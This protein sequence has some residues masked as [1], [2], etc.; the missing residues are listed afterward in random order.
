MRVKVDKEQAKDE[1]NERQIV[2]YAGC[3]YRAEL[4]EFLA[5]DREDTTCPKCHADEVI[6][7]I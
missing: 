2:S 7:E 5:K 1:R 6:Y 4:A 3:G